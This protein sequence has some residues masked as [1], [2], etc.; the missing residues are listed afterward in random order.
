MACDLPA[1]DVRQAQIENNHVGM[2]RRD[3]LEG[4]LSRGRFMHRVAVCAQRSSEESPDGRFVVN[5]QHSRPLF[6]HLFCSVGNVNFTSVPPCAA[7]SIQIRPWW[8]SMNPLQ[9]ERPRPA[10]LATPADA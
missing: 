6:S 7:R 8:A 5:D 1:T 3:D 4:L 9:M 2:N 10:P